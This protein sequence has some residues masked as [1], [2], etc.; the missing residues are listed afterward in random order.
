MFLKSCK[1]QKKNPTVEFFVLAGLLYNP[2]M[3]TMEQ[4]VKINDFDENENIIDGDI[5]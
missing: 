3:D 1:L 5:V 2:L 4:D